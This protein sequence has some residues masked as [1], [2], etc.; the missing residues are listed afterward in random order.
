MAGELVF[1]ELSKL[2]MSGRLLAYKRNLKFSFVKH[3]AE[4]FL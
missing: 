1:Y 3:N 4:L 2:Q